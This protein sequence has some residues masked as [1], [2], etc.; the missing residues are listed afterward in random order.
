M[1]ATKS[2]KRLSPLMVLSLPCLILAS[3]FLTI[4]YPSTVTMDQWRMGGENLSNTRSQP[5]ESA[6]GPSNVSQLVV[7]WVFAT[8]G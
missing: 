3:I 5:S 7:K 2:T 6:I 8:G 1:L 4:A